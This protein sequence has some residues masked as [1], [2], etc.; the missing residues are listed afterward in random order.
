MTK[1]ERTSSLRQGSSQVVDPA[2]VIDTSEV[3]V[4]GFV[5]GLEEPHPSLAAARNACEG[6]VNC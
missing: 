4:A 1:G 3:D 5:A 2:V 6:H